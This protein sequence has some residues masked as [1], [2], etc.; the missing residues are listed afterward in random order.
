LAAPPVLIKDHPTGLA[1]PLA[2]LTAMLT[3]S[4][5]HT[6]KVMGILNVTPDS[7]SDG[8][9]FFSKAKA[10]QRALQMV[11]EGADIID[12]GGESTRPYAQPVSVQVELDRVI[13]LVEKIHAELPVL[14]SVDTSKAQVMREAVVAGAHL[15]NDVAA[16]LDEGSLATVAACEQVSV[17]LMHRQ[18]NPQ[19]MQEHPCYQDVVSEVKSFLHL[20]AQAC[21]EAGI[22]PS[23]IILDPGFGFGKTLTHNL[24][25]LRHLE[26]FGQLGYPVM[27][28]ISR[29]SM[30]GQILN[31]PVRERLYGGLA[32]TALALLKGAK[33]IRTHDVA[34]TVDTLKSIQAVG[35]VATTLIT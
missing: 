29:K 31:K 20:R 9:L 26:V 28:G 15:I 30:L 16:L 27:I 1:R 18:G 3:S 23:R 17:V 24:Q 12:I 6:P 4:F 8:G 10:F 13:P 34:P 5:F 11:Q 21:I 19:T 22:A 32:L 33:I 7:F 25:L 35:E 14:I 2:N